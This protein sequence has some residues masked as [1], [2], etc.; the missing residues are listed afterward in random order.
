MV[1][2]RLV[3]SG[4]VQGV[5]FRGSCSQEADAAQVAGWARNLPDGG[6]EV[7]LEGPAEAVARVESWCHSGP[8]H[9]VVTAVM[10][11]DEDPTGAQGFAVI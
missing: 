7:V 6:V 5:W 3:I 11:E 10:G 8:R 4:R 9:A 2:R 1:R